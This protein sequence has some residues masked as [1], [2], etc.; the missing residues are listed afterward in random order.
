ML[1]RARRT[2]RIETITYINIYNELLP[3]MHALARATNGQEIVSDGNVIGRQRIAEQLRNACR[4]EEGERILK[5]HH[6]PLDRDGRISDSDL[7]ALEVASVTSNLGNVISADDGGGR[8]IESA[9]KD[10]R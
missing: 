3:L 5:R 4:T 6:I 10:C 7:L 1:T 2:P 8:V 9:R